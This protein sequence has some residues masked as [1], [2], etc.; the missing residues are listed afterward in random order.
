MNKQ[1]IR[2]YLR[3]KT[4]MDAHSEQLIDECIQEVKQIAQFK[5]VYQL[6]CLSHKP[7]MLE[8]VKLL[9]DSKDLAFYLQECKQCMI[10]ACTLG[11]LIDR[12]MKYYEHLD[13]SKAVVFDAVS[14]AYL[15]ECCDAYQKT[16]GFESYT[17]RLAPGYGDIPLELN[18][19]FASLLEMNKKLGV[20]F[21][22]AG[23]LIPMKSMIGI[24]GIGQKVKKT[25]L[26]CLRKESCELRRGGQRCYV[27][28]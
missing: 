9:L 4:L 6:Y 18:K 1:V 15:E 24:V 27:K 7:L 2:H 10:I 12:Q 5:V 3:A 13:M 26:S 25:C 8:E 28:D 14:N 22:D 21:N 16:L 19:S 20:S 23:L 11:V 17:F